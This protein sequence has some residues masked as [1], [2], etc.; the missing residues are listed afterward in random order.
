MSALF[1]FTLAILVPLAVS[2][3]YGHLNTRTAVRSLAE[4]ALLELLT[5]FRKDDFKSANSFVWHDLQRLVPDLENGIPDQHYE[6][7]RSVMHFYDHLGL[8]VKAGIIDDKY[9]IAFMG[10]S[11]CKT[12]RVLEPYIKSRRARS[13]NQHYQA[14]FEDLAARAASPGPAAVIG[15]LRLKSFDGDPELHAAMESVATVWS[16]PAA[17]PPQTG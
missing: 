5:E 11:T 3:T 10:G 9:V 2:I 12:W 16:P 13:S 7:V 1:T 6:R 14:F 17:E 15:R 4:P 8:V